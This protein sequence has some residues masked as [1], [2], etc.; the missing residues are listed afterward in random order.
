MKT[1]ASSISKVFYGTLIHSRSIKEIEYIK[2]GLLFIDTQGKIAKL[3]KDVAQDKVDASLEG[4]EAEKVT[5]LTSTSSTT[6]QHT[7]LASLLPFPAPRFSSFLLLLDLVSLPPPCIFFFKPIGLDCMHVHWLC[8]QPRC[9][10][11]CSDRD[12]PNKEGSFTV[13]VAKDPL[14]LYLC[15]RSPFRVALFQ[16]IHSLI[17]WS[18][19][20]TLFDPHSALFFYSFHL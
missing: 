3:V 15:P 14:F 11:V 7:Q 6:L 16:G 4:V 5:E 20:L 10:R 19:A 13:C 1:F 18:G 2:Q 12:E 8:D 9:T 17:M